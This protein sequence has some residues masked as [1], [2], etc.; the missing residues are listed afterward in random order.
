MS[1]TTEK[2]DFTNAR[3]TKVCPT[4]SGVS[5]GM[6]EKTYFY[7]IS[8]K[9]AVEQNILELAAVNFLKLLMFYGVNRG[10]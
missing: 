3:A 6:Y 10:F 4:A 5:A 7:A 9:I 2:T 1:K 8:W